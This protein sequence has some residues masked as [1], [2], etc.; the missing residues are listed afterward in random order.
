[1]WRLV[2]E[3][4]ERLNVQVFA[5]THSRDC[6]EALAAISTAAKARAF[7][8]SVDAFAPFIAWARK[9]FAVRRCAGAA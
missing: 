9:L 4:A 5:T 2:F 3:A 7:D 6:Y 8:T 1:M